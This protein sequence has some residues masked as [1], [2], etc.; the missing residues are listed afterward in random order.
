MPQIPQLFISVIYFSFT[1]F[2]PLPISLLFLFDIRDGT[3][4]KPAAATS[5]Y[6]SSLSLKHHM[7]YAR[8]FNYPLIVDVTK[9]N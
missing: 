4:M 6:F 7:K 8:N 9:E 5:S 3:N 1:Q 2:W